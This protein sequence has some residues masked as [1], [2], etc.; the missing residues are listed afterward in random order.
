MPNK[1]STSQSASQ[2]AGQNFESDDLSVKVSELLVA[3]ADQ[4]D[5]A[6]DQS[7]R[8]VLALLRERMAMDVVFVS[9]FVEGQ[10]A[11]R[12][13]AQAPGVKLLTEGHSDP[14]EASWCQR[15]VDGRLP[16][17]MAD[18][19]QHPAA[20][21]LLKDL[22]HPIGTHIS[23]PVVLSS[24]EVFG[25]LCCFSFQPNGQSS[26]EDLSRLKMTARLAAH[27]LEQR[28]Q[29]RPAPTEVPTWTL[30]PK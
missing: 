11:F 4:S 25:T 9:E 29:V 22:S 30:K 8:E 21:L 28:R 13:V 23:T 2:S 16:Q 26:I 10:R 3:T 7:I 27:R 24:G 5:E 19:R 15:V 18:A 20:A 6:L 17:F 12:Q 14:L 1:P